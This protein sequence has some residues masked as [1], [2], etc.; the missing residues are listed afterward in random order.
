MLATRTK[1][2]TCTDKTMV[3]SMPLE[4]REEKTHF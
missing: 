3:K 1:K 2:F 4:I